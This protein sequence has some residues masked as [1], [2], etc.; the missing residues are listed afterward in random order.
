MHD[1]LLLLRKC[2]SLDQAWR[3][4]LRKWHSLEMSCHFLKQ[5]RDRIVWISFKGLSIKFYWETD[6]TN[7]HIYIMF[8]SIHAMRYAKIR[9]YIYICMYSCVAFYLQVYICV[10]S[11]MYVSIFLYIYIYFF[12]FGTSPSNHVVLVCA[13]RRLHVHFFIFGFLIYIYI[14]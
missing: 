3:C 8:V 9:I 14:Y 11:C 12:L 1:R 13:Q 6:M 10:C 2:Q 4:L 7:T 5:R